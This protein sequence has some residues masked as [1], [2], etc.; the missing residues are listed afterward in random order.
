MS[1][2]DESLRLILQGKDPV[3]LETDIQDPRIVKIAQD[4][5]GLTVN[6]DLPSSCEY[7]TISELNDTKTTPESTKFFHLNTASL[8]FHFETI[9]AILNNCDMNF[10]FIGI[11]ETR[12][13]KNVLPKTKTAIKNYEFLD[14]PTEASKGGVRI[15]IS[16]KHRFV[17]RDDLKNL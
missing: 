7:Y 3:N 11:T 14:C 12:I 2:D 10:D 9:Q 1:C 5:D 16:K 17:P 8:G 13:L 6:D 15:Y 4:I